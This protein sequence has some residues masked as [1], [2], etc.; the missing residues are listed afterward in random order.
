[1][2]DLRHIAQISK[3]YNIFT[4]IRVPRGNAKP[5]T[6]RA[7][8]KDNFATRKEPT[9]CGSHILEDYIS[10]FDATSVRLLENSG[11]ASVVGKTNLDEFGMGNSTLN[12][13]YGPT[14]NPLYNQTEDIVSDY[15]QH[16]VWIPVKKSDQINRNVIRT[17]PPADK[18]DQYT[19]ISYL[20]PV[21]SKKKQISPEMRIVGG[22]SGGAAA[23]VATDLVDFAI[24]SDTGGSIRL[25]ACYTSTL[26]F[27]PSYGRISRWGL[28]SY[29]Q[30]LDTVG[31][32]SKKLPIISKVFKT[33]DQYDSSDPTSLASNKRLGDDFKQPAKFRIG[34]PMEFQLENMGSDIKKIWMDLLKRLSDSKLIE[35]YP[36]SIPSIKSALPTYYTLVT[37]EASSNL[38]RFDGIRYGYRADEYT[39]TEPE[40]T[41]T[42]FKGFGDEVKRRITLGT[43][44]LSSYGFDSHFMKATKL[45]S[46][47]I[48]EFN[49][50][51]K[52]R[53]VLFPDGKGNVKGVDF[54][55]CPTSV[56]KPP[57]V[58]NFYKMKPVESYLNDVLTIPASLAG[59]PTVNV[60]FGGKSMG[61]QVMGQYDCD[62]KVLQF[63]EK[64]I[65]CIN[66]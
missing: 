37:A 27:K 41:V 47:L 38:S 50:V 66:L 2:N 10:P 14:L 13:Y 35:I 36:V 29:A 28:I 56:S 18:V 22:S 16:T 40:F 24:G 42:R 1:M 52:D 51:F 25:P 32:I 58:S 55:I 43:F 8:I 23:S 31:I 11:L 34:I 61:F 17:R 54:I 63:V 26:G 49:A 53:H 7:S 59:L 39:D 57:L 4:S 21:I 15:K 6:L 48:N 44:S 19:E 12:S 46:R 33:L 5:G 20:K 62:Y 45:R 65:E 3:R 60:P 9:T 64:M 30:S